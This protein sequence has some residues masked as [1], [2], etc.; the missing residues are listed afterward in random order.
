MWPLA[1]CS[2]T[3]LELHFAGTKAPPV[4][5]QHHLRKENVITAIRHCDASFFTDYTQLNRHI[6]RQGQSNNNI[7]I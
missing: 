4:T 6:L 1:Q 5:V 3:T 7:L 2:D